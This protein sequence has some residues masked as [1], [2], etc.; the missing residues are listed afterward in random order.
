MIL[1]LHWTGQV[2][3]NSLG[4]LSPAS[5]GHT[6]LYTF[7][8]WTRI[9]E[10]FH[11]MGRFNTEKCPLGNS[12]PSLPV[13]G[14]P[15]T[16]C[17]DIYASSSQ[18]RQVLSVHVLTHIHCTCALMSSFNGIKCTCNNPRKPW[19]FTAFTQQSDTVNSYRSK[20]QST[21]HY[22][23]K[24][25][26]RINFHLLFRVILVSFKTLKQYFLMYIL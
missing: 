13:Y 16:F 2:F 24:W 19:W 9:L 26:P 12:L 18:S 1:F 10:Y 5:K 4:L 3:C 7:F 15:Y 8:N 25:K 14:H 20:L 17:W 6:Y 21:F 22:R 23:W 11:S